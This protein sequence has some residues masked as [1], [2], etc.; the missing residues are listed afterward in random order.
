MSNKDN[1]TVFLSRPDLGQKEQDAC[2]RVIRSGFLVQ[3]PECEAFEQEFASVVGAKYSVAVS[4]GTAA[5]L[6]SLKALGLGENDEVIIPSYTFIA[7]ANAVSL[8]GAEVALVD[9]Q[10]DTMNMDPKSVAAV[11][12]E[13]TSLILPVHQYGLGADLQAISQ[14]APKVTIL[15]D[16]ACAFGTELAGKKIGSGPGVL[17]CFSFHPRKVISTGE[18]GMVTTNNLGLAERIKALRQHGQGSGGTLEPGYNMRMAE[19]PAALGRV[20]LQR[21][22][23][24]IAKR[25]QVAQ[26]YRESL[27]DLGWLALPVHTPGRVYQ[28][29]VVRLLDNAPISRD[30]LIRG[31]QNASIQCQAGIAPVHMHAPYRNAKRSPLPVSESLASS[32]LFLPMH[33]G[34]RRQDVQ[35]VCNAICILGGD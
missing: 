4:S 6:L 31:L 7:T 10:A 32:A 25:N 19:I 5:L 18:G 34:L 17:T 9:V 14:S 13:N 8:A 12:S 24:F 21:L 26:W 15:E 29:Y 33:Y 20:Q 28:S 2:L 27:G 35:R 16:A 1:Q 30:E 3:G 23:E 22:D 11:L